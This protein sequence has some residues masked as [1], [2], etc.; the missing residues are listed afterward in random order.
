MENNSYFTRPQNDQQNICFYRQSDPA[1]YDFTSDL[2]GKK[3][4]FRPQ[5]VEDVIR[6]GYLSIP[7]AEPETAILSDKKHTAWLG[8]DDIIGQVRNRFEVYERN[9]YE[10]EV[11]CPASE[12]WDVP[13]N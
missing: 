4:Y 3:A 2:S 13:T 8:L 12:V 7:K 5:T 6:H 10:L 1:D 11:V 9:I